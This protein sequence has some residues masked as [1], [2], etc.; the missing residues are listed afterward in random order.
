MA[1]GNFAPSLSND[2][3]DT[4]IT[5]D[6]GWSWTAAA[7]KKRR[8][9]W[10]L[11]TRGRGWTDG[12]PLGWRVGVPMRLCSRIVPGLRAARR[13]PRRIRWFTLKQ[14]RRLGVI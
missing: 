1:P 12:S 2:T 7:T 4:S 9:A 6:F 3:C 14:L 10:L 13:A 11:F 5:I 8:A